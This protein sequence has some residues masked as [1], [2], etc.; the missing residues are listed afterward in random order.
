MKG[1][2]IF[3]FGLTDLGHYERI[4]QSQVLT[5]LAIALLEQ[6]LERLTAETNTAAANW[7]IQQLQ[8]LPQQPD[9]IAESEQDEE[10]NV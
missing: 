1:Q 4:E 9:C 7:L 8:N 5:G 3:A 2:R 6:T 10:N